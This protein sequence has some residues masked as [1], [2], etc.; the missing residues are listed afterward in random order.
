MKFEAWG[1]TVLLKHF[2]KFPLKIKNVVVRR[3]H[4]ELVEGLQRWQ[5][6]AQ[7]T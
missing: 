5:T 4:P 6:K 7:R 2:T 1:F 3:C